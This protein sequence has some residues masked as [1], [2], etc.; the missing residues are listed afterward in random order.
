MES[1]ADWGKRG[2][3]DYVPTPVYRIRKDYTASVQCREKSHDE[4]ARLA[5]GLKLVT[6]KSVAPAEVGL[7]S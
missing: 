6:A 2:H 4:Y 3:E 7:N 1:S 5:R